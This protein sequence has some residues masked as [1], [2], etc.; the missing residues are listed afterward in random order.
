MVEDDAEYARLVRE[1]LSQPGVIPQKFQ[2]QWADRLQAGIDSLSKGGIDV[3]LLDLMLPDSEG[4]NTVLKLRAHKRDIPIVVMTNINDGALALQAMSQGAQD[5]M[6]KG[7]LD[8]PLLKRAILYA[9]ERSR[10]VSDLENVVERSADGMVIVDKEGIV[11]YVNPAAEVIFD[12]RAA[13]MLGRPFGFPVAPNKALELRIP[14]RHGGEKT[15]EMKVTELEWKNYSACL[16]SIRDIT[17][18]KRLEQLKAEIREKNRM[19]QMKDQFMSTVSHELRSPLTVIKA[20]IANLAE[21]LAGALTEPQSKIVSLAQRNVD[22]L[23]KIINNLLD[24]SRLESGI[25]RIQCRKLDPMRLVQQTAQGFQ[26]V[27]QERGIV[28]QTALHPNLPF[29]YADGDMVV[30]VLNNLLDNA[31][32]FAKTKVVV[33][34]KAV[35]SSAAK[36]P[37]PVSFGGRGDGAAILLDRGI[38]VSVVDDG[39]GIAQDRIGDLFNK[40]VQVNRSVGGGY[41]G[42]GLGLAI[43]KEIIEQHQGRIWVE[44]G[45][46]RGAKFHFVLPQYYGEKINAES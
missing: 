21:G 9:I 26:M 19:D 45:L 46:G 24:L 22:R 6:L 30:Q 27:G 37:R 25:A 31:L 40:F 2:M 15:A 12:R 17:V 5:Y 29:V 10:M 43:C 16:A 32:R 38:L 4:I 41:K 13:E 3:V 7:S 8:S 23:A 20:A 34:V 39:P 1:L 33:E 18:L 11:R 14:L 35:I 28:L 44:S 36:E 42:T